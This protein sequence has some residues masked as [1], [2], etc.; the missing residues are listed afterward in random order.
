MTRMLLI[1]SVFLLSASAGAF[2]QVPGGQLNNLLG[3]QGELS[4]GQGDFAQSERLALAISSRRYPVTPGDTYV[5]TFSSGGEIAS[6]TVTVQS[7]YS[8]NLNIFGEFDTEGMTYTEL[9]RDVESVVRR[10]YPQSLPSFRL[11]SV[12]LFEVTVRGAI[13]ETTRATAWGLSRLSN[14]VQPLLR[15]F[16]SKRRVIVTSREGGLESYDLFRAVRAGI[17]GQDPHLRPGDAVRVL[18]VGS[19]VTVRGEVNEPGRYEILSGETISD[20]V[21]HAGGFSPEAEPGAVR[22]GRREEGRT[23]TQTLDVS[24]AGAQGPALRDGDR[25]TVE[26]VRRN[27]PVVFIEGAL[28]T[29]EEPDPNRQTIEV[30]EEDLQDAEAGYLR[31]SESFYEGLMLSDV[32]FELRQRLAP[33]ADLQRASVIRASDGRAIEVDASQLLYGYGDASDIELSPFDTIFIP[34]R[35]VSVLVNGPVANPGLY[36]YVPGQTPEYYIQRAG[37]YDREV[38]ATGAYAVFDTRGVRREEGANVQPGDRIELERNNFVYQFNRH[39]PVIVSGLS[40]VTT[41]ISVFALI[42]Q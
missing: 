41:V 16:S 5:L 9:K 29:E 22:L 31:V 20:V 12:G 4:A 19:L 42:S 39:F 7:D 6:T 13:S 38:S 26:S 25:I 34:S 10:A 24:A 28:Q 27:Q 32:L 36:L 17:E 3:G 21:E 15:P 1:V 33:F 8:L 18:P 40:L 14:V 2:A 37:G 30:I 11:V 35:A 23:I